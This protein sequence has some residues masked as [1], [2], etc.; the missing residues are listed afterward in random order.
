MISAISRR[1]L[2]FCSMAGMISSPQRRSRK[3]L[4]VDHEAKKLRHVSGG[5]SS[6]LLATLS[7]WR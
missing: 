2:A 3:V 4:M 5:I 1:H 6:I 7:D